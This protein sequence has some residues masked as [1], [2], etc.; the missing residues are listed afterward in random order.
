MDSLPLAPFQVSVS[1]QDLS[2]P[3]EDR[4]GSISLPVYSRTLVYWHSIGACSCLYSSSVI[5][6]KGSSNKLLNHSY[7]SSDS[8]RRAV[9][10]QQKHFN[11][12]QIGS[13]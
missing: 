6:V 7:E 11:R 1:L 13:L 12:Q 5:L 9:A 2:G 3:D 8:E 10:K 4:A